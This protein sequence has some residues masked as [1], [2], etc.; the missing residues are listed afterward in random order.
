MY[1]V[2]V[3]SNLVDLCI[4]DTGCLQEVRGLPLPSIPALDVMAPEPS[5]AAALSLLDG[6]DVPQPSPA[7]PAE[8]RHCQSMFLEPCRQFQSLTLRCCCTLCLAS[9]VSCTALS[10]KFW[11]QP[12]AEEEV[13]VE[14]RLQRAAQAEQAAKL[15]RRQAIAKIAN[16]NGALPSQAWKRRLHQ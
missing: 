7:E 12:S 15:S 13:G 14:E 16:L 2:F 8:V 10:S 11:P 9:L 5:S 1:L 4:L 6:L 3:E